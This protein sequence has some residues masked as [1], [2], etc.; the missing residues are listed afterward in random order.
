MMDIKYIERLDL[1]L[2]KKYSSK[3]FAFISKEEREYVEQFRNEKSKIEHLLGVVLRRKYLSQFLSVTPEELIFDIGEKGKPF[4]SNFPNIY[5]NI[6]HGGKYIVLAISNNAVG[7]DVEMWK[8]KVNFEIITRYF[9][10]KEIE[11]LSHLTIEARQQLFFQYW[12]AKESYLKMLGTGL[13]KLLSSFSIVFNKEKISILEEDIL[14]NDVNLFQFNP[15]NEHIVTVCGKNI[16][17]KNINIQKINIK[18]L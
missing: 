11:Q 7:V 4:C 2:L 6:S 15:D 12:T 9:S 3:F 13:T 18:N 17:K 8:R 1:D 10:Q 16:L 5:F 14:L